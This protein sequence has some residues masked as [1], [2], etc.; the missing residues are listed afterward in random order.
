MF[1]VL[2]KVVTISPKLRNDS[3][4][5][6]VYEFIEKMG[7]LDYVCNVKKNSPIE[8]TGQLKW[9]TS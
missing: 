3:I 5:H 7:F 6:G 1:R 4:F 9:I 8:G 2:K